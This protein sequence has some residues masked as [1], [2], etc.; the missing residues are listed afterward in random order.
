MG[1]EQSD[2]ILPRGWL[3]YVGFGLGAGTVP[4][5]PYAE[6]LIQLW[7]FSIGGNKLRKKDLTF[8][9]SYYGTEPRWEEKSQRMLTP[10][11]TVRR[12]SPQHGSF[13]SPGE[14]WQ[15][16]WCEGAAESFL[17]EWS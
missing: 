8:L 6:W 11:K 10:W 16:R 5:R 13:L 2:A 12:F 7:V 9:G 1:S 4:G 14:F 17:C 3:R 15:G